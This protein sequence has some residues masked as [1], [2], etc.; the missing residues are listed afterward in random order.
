MRDATVTQPH[1]AQCLYAAITLMVYIGGMAGDLPWLSGKQGSG[2][3]AA[4]AGQEQ[5]P[6]T[7]MQHRPQHAALEQQPAVETSCKASA[8]ELRESEAAE[9][10][11]EDEGWELLASAAPDSSA[12]PV[13]PQQDAA[14]G[15]ARSLEPGHSTQPGLTSGQAEAGRES[16][17]AG[18]KSSC[19]KAD[20]EGMSLQSGAHERAE[21]SGRGAHDGDVDMHAE[22]GGRS[23]LYPRSASTA[24]ELT[25]GLGDQ[26]PGTPD[27]R[28]HA[29][30]E[31]GPD[32]KEHDRLDV[33]GQEQI[34]AGTEAAATA[35]FDREEVLWRCTIFTVQVN[36][37]PQ[38][39]TLLHATI[40]V[41]GFRPCY[42]D[43]AYWTP[44]TDIN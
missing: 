38:L 37:L 4:L 8:S 3:R 21:S 42:V 2:Q 6:V 9:D 32:E 12:Q 24:A 17:T 23:L 34:V 5:E 43:E 39:Q 1:A 28:D 36:T 29:S 13:L 15:A 11:D 30:H 35:A 20:L 18:D 19:A 41:P 26:P 22:T 25:R 7:A 33:S 14:V 27:T 44:P 16:G 31:H 10:E 40:N